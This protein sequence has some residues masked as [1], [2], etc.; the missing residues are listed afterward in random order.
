MNSYLY[1]LWQMIFIHIDV[2]IISPDD[3]IWNNWA[4][5]FLFSFWRNNQAR[6]LIHWFC[7]MWFFETSRLWL[8][9]KVFQYIK[10]KCYN[11]KVK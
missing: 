9:N 6:N 1:I 2:M 11:T 8:L 4:L 5:I 7:L 10:D 3:R